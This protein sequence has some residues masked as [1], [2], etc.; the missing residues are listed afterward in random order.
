M[1]FQKPI[2]ANLSQRFGADFM[3]NGKWYYKQILGYLGH[4]GDDYAA[5]FGVPVY[6]ADEGT[7]AFEGWGQNHSWMGAPAGICALIDNG[8]VY[9]GYAHLSST[10]VNKGQ[11]ITKGQHIGFV[12]ATGAATGNHLHFEALPKAPNFQNGYAGRID[13]NQFMDTGGSVSAR[14]TKEQAEVL[15]YCMRVL[16][17][18]A[19]G[20]DRKEVHEGKADRKE[21]DHLASYNLSAVD[22]IASYAQQAWDEGVS[23]RASKDAW[24][25]AFNERPG[26]LQ[27]ITDQ[28]KE[29]EQLKKNQGGIDQATKDQIANTNSIVQWIKDKLNSIFK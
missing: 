17:S 25:A 12:G 27:R 2:N 29:I 14:I 1:S 5:N 15:K 9:S 11:R 3:S 19:K 13:P 18:E 8:G 6:A 24:K 28:Q 21:V 20:W 4:N 22:A 10:V 16:N 26:L 7:V 23:Y